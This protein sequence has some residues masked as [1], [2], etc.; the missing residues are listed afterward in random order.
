VATHDFYSET[1]NTI[2]HTYYQWVWLVLF[3]QALAF[4]MPRYLWKNMECGRIRALTHN[5]DDFIQDDETK[6]KRKRD[7]LEYFRETLGKNDGYSMKYALCEVLN[8]INVVVQ[9]DITDRFLG[10][11]LSKYGFQ[12]LNWERRD[13][14]YRTDPLAVVFPTVTKCTFA[15]VGPSGNIINFDSLCVLPI[16]V[17]N[18]KFYPLLW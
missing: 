13:P 17:Y 3:F 1:E 16:N 12:L 14:M 18:E 6:D 2:V 9:I 8:F 4:F 10:R 15:M 11:A 7:C 5:L